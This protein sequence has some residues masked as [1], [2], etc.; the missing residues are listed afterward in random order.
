MP[1]EKYSRTIKQSECTLG[2]SH[3]RP[4]LVVFAGVPGTGKT[5]LAAHAARKLQAPA[6]GIDFIEAALWRSGIASELGSHNAAYELLSTLAESQLRRGQSACIDAVAGWRS[7]REAWAALAYRYR[8]TI[9]FVEC[10]CSDIEIH[11]RRIEGRERNIPG[12][13]ELTWADVERS[14]RGYDPWHGERLVL[15]AA[16][17]LESNLADLDAYLSNQISLRRPTQGAEAAPQQRGRYRTD[18]PL[19]ISDSAVRPTDNNG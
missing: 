13:Y 10:V 1:C 7:T 17:P 4:F 18:T 19:S 8:A 6:F 9:R 11:R 5:T 15:D 14:M 16:S 2:T 3:C 12:W